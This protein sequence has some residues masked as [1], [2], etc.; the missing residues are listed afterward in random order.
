MVRLMDKKID[1]L[2]S[3]IEKLDRE[4]IDLSDKV[5]ELKTI[6]S[7]ISSLMESKNGNNK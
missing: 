1:Y 5:W 4:I 3:K 6:L 2:L 7:S